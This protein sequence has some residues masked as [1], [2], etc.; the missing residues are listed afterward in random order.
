MIQENTYMDDICFFMN[1]KQAKKTT[2]I[3]DILAAGGFKVK[4]WSS[5]EDMD[6]KKAAE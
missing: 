5:N 3:D 2:E 4:G 1:T 6:S